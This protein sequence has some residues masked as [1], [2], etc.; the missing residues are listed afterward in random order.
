[1]CRRASAVPVQRRTSNSSLLP[2]PARP[3]RRRHRPLHTVNRSVERV[4]RPRRLLHCLRRTNSPRR[5][6]RVNS[7]ANATRHE[8][9]GQKTHPLA[10]P[11]KGTPSAA[12]PSYADASIRHKVHVTPGPESQSRCRAG[13]RVQRG[14]SMLL[15]ADDRACLG[16]C[17]SAIQTADLAMPT[18]RV[19][20]IGLDPH[21]VPG[22]ESQDPLDP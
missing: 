5:P 19:L 21:R 10:L 7:P 14:A 16:S 1:M 11:E 22:P 2:L 15:R 6:D 18:P 9:P 20:V 3:E 12:A 17:D 13:N 8:Q 4:H